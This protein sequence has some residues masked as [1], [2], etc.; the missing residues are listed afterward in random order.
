[1][2]LEGFNAPVSKHFPAMET[3]SQKDIYPKSRSI[4]DESQQQRHHLNTAQLIQPQAPWQKRRHT[5]HFTQN[6][7]I[8]SSSDSTTELQ[9][10]KES[11]LNVPGWGCG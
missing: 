8:V 10:C 9:F 1:L 2:K 4:L 7:G 3:T 6:L 11:P 5:Q